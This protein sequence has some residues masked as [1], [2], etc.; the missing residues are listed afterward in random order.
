M[1]KYLIFTLIT[2]LIALESCAAKK[3]HYSE[4]R[5]ETNFGKMIFIWE[6]LIGF[7]LTFFARFDWMQEKKETNKK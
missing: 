2:V 5:F 7:G 6:F 1:K 3:N 4:V